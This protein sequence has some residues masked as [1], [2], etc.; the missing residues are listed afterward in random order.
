MTEHAQQMA[1]GTIQGVHT[2]GMT[3]PLTLRKAYIFIHEFSQWRLLAR[4]QTLEPWDTAATRHALLPTNVSIHTTTFHALQW[5]VQRVLTGRT[6]GVSRA[7]RLN[8]TA[9]VVYSGVR[10]ANQGLIRI[11][12]VLPVVS[13]VLLAHTSMKKA[14]Q[15]VTHVLSANIVLMSAVCSALIVPLGHTRTRPGQR[16]VVTAPVAPTNPTTA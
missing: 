13:L 2:A 5:I 6:D 14:K 11:R 1:H 9:E 15:A 3:G 8:I 12:P 7:L 16:H 4:Y 10:C